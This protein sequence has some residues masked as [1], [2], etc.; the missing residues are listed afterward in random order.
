MKEPTFTHS[1]RVCRLQREQLRLQSS[2]PS[3]ADALSSRISILRPPMASP[4]RSPSVQ[5]IDREQRTYRA[6]THCRQRKS[7]CIFNDTPGKT[8]CARC[9]YSRPIPVADLYISFL[10]QVG[11]KRASDRGI[12]NMPRSR[13]VSEIRECVGSSHFAVTNSVIK[14]FL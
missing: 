8:P 14:F 9:T 2:T 4:K 10:S 13:T 12:G 7:R 3:D 1:S 5:K 6:C 11:S